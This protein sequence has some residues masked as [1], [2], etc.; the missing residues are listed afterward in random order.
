MPMP[1]ATNVPHCWIADRHEALLKFSKDFG[2]HLV[3]LHD[4]SFAD[5]KRFVPSVVVEKGVTAVITYD[6]QIAVAIVGTRD[7]AGERTST[8]R[9]PG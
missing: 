1:R 6:H 8:A 5:G 3:G 4:V 9:R 7:R 2:F